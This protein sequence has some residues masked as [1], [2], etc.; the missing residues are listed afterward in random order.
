[1][2]RGSSVAI[3]NSTY[4][5][6]SAHN[7]ATNPDYWAA[8]P[9]DTTGVDMDFFH[10]LNRTIAGVIPILDPTVVVHYRKSPGQI[11][12]IVVGTIVPVLLIFATAVFWFVRRRKAQRAE[13][14]MVAAVRLGAAEMPD[15]SSVMTTKERISS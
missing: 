12:E 6:A 9:L 10:C 4:D 14:E 2:Y 5:N 8:T 15:E 13:A 7:N 1:Y 3:G 11:A